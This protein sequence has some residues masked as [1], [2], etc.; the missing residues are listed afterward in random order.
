MLSNIAEG[1]EACIQL[2]VAEIP[3]SSRGE[4]LKFYHAYN[5]TGVCYNEDSDSRGLG[6]GL[7]FC[8]LMLLVGGP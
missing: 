2:T 3:R 5:L 8:D 6:W 4:L 7:R 1:R